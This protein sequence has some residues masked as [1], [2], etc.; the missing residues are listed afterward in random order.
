MQNPDD[1]KECNLDIQPDVPDPE[2]TEDEVEQQNKTPDNSDIPHADKYKQKFV[3]G[4]NGDED[5]NAENEQEKEARKLAE[6]WKP[7]N[8]ESWQRHS[9]LGPNVNAESKTTRKESMPELVNLVDH[10]WCNS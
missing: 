8:R 10:D 9:E 3:F 4:E 1:N 7:E 5:D 2:N 6:R